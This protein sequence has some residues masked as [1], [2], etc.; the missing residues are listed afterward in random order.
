[1]GV[2]PR[3]AT[4]PLNEGVGLTGDGYPQFTVLAFYVD[5]GLAFASPSAHLARCEVG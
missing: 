2:I 5:L 4:Y 1:M 3:L